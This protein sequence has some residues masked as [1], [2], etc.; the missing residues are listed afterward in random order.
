MTPAD[1]TTM[2]PHVSPRVNPARHVALQTL[3][4][5]ENREFKA[6]AE[7][8][9]TR[10][11]EPRELSGRDRRLA[12]RIV[13]GC[14]RNKTLLEH[15]LSRY[16]RTPVVELDLPLRWILVAGLYQLLCLSQPAY[17]V[18]NESQLL[19]NAW[20][21][22]S[23][24]GLV[25]AVLRAAIRDGLTAVSMQAC[26]PDLATRYSH[27][28]WMVKRWCAQF[29]ASATELILEW[30]NTLPT[31]YARIRDP[32]PMAVIA[33]LGAACSEAQ[34]FGSDII[35]IFDIQAV[36]KSESFED[37]KLYIADPWSLEC[38]R[39][40]PV[41]DGWRILDLCAAPGGKSIAL[42][43]RATV[44]VIAADVS[45]KRLQTLIANCARC[46]CQSIQP[47]VLDGVQSPAAFGRHAF[48]CVIVDAPCSNLGVVQRHPEIRW[49]LK[50]EDLPQLQQLQSNLLTAA[51]Q[52]VKPGGYLLY[53]V[54]TITPEETRDVAATI[55]DFTVVD[56]HLRLPGEGGM[57]GGFHVLWQ[58]GSGACE[59]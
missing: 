21:R 47:M 22:A 15:A 46:R 49:R 50:P 16:C 19:C 58:C 35:R 8:I 57:N 55:T 11:C 4:N 43:D 51:Q 5:L 30:H 54:C 9:L 52:C 56:T 38:L 59:T 18:V 6:H 3:C 42:A 23:W 44:S 28:E 41:C 7:D 10:A 12:Y 20:Q 26:A 37:G 25:N 2:E 33:A 34:E 29:G 48:D 53:A 13:E 24:R 40:L 36:L 31:H 32:D 39:P 17:A 45:A 27:P 1:R 14:L